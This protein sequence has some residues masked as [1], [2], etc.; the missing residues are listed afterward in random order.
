VTRPCRACG[1][2]ITCTGNRSGYHAACARP[3]RVCRRPVDPGQARTR[4]CPGCAELLALLARIH[5]ADDR[6]RKL[7]L[8]EGRC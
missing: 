8:Q 6:E 1:K 5:R 2:P 4:T 7:R 3:C